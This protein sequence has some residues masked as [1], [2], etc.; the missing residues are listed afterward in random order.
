MHHRQQT[1]T[2][3]CCLAHATSPTST[4]TP[5]LSRPS[6]SEIGAAH[7]RDPA[8]FLPPSHSIAAF[9][10]IATFT[11]SRLAIRCHARGGSKSTVFGGS[12]RF[13]IRARFGS[14]EAV[15]LSVRLKWRGSIFNS[16][17]VPLESGT[18]GGLLLEGGTPH[19]DVHGYGTR[20]ISLLGEGSRSAAAA[21]APPS[22]A[23]SGALTALAVPPRHSATDAHSTAGSSACNGSPLDVVTHGD[24]LLGAGA[25][26]NSSSVSALLDGGARD[27][28][29]VSGGA[30]GDS[31]LLD[32]GACDDAPSRAL[33][34]RPATCDEPA[35]LLDLL[36]ETADELPP[37]RR[38]RGVSIKTRKRSRKPG[39][40][41]GKQR[42]V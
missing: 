17:G 36:E 6:E 40:Q 1:S 9:I 32:D 29:L 22:I 41:R 18:H 28:S 4:P 23:I 30:C 19:G 33:S 13:A 3:R 38:A 34:A 2:G 31:A 14:Q 10:S 21:A 42:V 35:S 27:S 15:A 37:E 12:G 39:D 16:G 20:N 26:D 11:R 7:V 5:F 25:P 8:L 24:A